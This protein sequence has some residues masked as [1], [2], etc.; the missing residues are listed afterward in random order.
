MKKVDRYT[1]KREVATVKEKAHSELYVR[2]DTRK[3]KKNLYESAR[4][5]DCVGNKVKVVKDKDGN[6]L[7]SEDSAFRRWKEYFE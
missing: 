5:I 1:S 3:E 7:T 2:L 4:K 6:I